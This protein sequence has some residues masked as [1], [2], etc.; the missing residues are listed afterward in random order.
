[1]KSRHAGW[2]L[3]KFSQIAREPITPT[4]DLSRLR[5]CT[6]IPGIGNSVVKF[7]VR[8]GL[9]HHAISQNRLLGE[10]PIPALRDNFF[11]KNI[12]PQKHNARILQY[13][14]NIRW[15]VAR[16]NRARRM[17][18]GKPAHGQR[19]WSNA[20]TTRTCNIFLQNILRA[21]YSEILRYRSIKRIRYSKQ[22]EMRMRA[23]VHKPK[24]AQKW[25]KFKS[26]LAR[27]VARKTAKK[28]VWR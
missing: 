24:K 22:L 13:L 16:S 3:F 17:A 10:T 8:L 2:F 1:M 5:C 12:I 7:V 21:Y 27:K 6:N 18:R 25:H 4:N 14:Y 26:K 28:S 11:T 9:Y 20:N 19:T 15:Y 23:K